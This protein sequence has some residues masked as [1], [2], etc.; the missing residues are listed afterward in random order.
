MVDHRASRF[1][2]MYSA[3]YSKSKTSLVAGIQLFVLTSPSPFS[4]TPTSVKPPFLR[5]SKI[6]LKI[7]NKKL[8]PKSSIIIKHLGGSLHRHIIP[9]GR[10]SVELLSCRDSPRFERRLCRA[11]VGVL[12][13]VLV[14]LDAGANP[15]A[16][17]VPPA[18]DHRTGGV[19]VA[20]VA[21]H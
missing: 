17:F 6:P 19:S 11:L 5:Q 14:D 10:V 2:R 21:G 16:L 8:P 9:C 3:L 7:L 12:G 15:D 13:V 4:V 20:T 18:P 1:G